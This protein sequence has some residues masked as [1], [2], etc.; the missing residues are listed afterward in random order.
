MF[1]FFAIFLVAIQ[2]HSGTKD[3]Y[4]IGNGIQI[5]ARESN[6]RKALVTSLR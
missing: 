2:G 3:V 4:T 6:V 5:C 1:Y